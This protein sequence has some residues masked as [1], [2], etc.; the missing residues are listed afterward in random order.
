MIVSHFNNN[1]QSIKLKL[2]ITCIVEEIAEGKDN[3]N[4]NDNSSN[5]KLSREQIEAL[6]NDLDG[7]EIIEKLIE[8]SD[9]F[10][11]KTEFSK[12][13]YLKKKK[14]KYLAVFQVLQPNSRTLCD[15]FMQ[16]KMKRKIL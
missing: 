6:K 16:G 1:F 7:E 3:R 4:L 8:N 13:K 15:Y 10:N 11:T 2:C 5:Q 12:Q 9:T 14:E